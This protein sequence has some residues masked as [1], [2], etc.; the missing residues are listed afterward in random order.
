[1]IEKIVQDYLADALGVSVLLEMPEEYAPPLVILQ[2]TGGGRENRIPSAMI[3]AQS[4]GRSLY[5]AARLNEAVKDAMDRLVEVDSV[6]AV[7]L[8]SDYNFTDEESKRYRYQA[9]FD[10]VHY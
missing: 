5:E 6:S 1:M 2:K 8:N 7:S 4:Y 9:V 10:L 3:A